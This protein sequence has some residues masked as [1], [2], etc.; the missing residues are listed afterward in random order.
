MKRLIILVPALSALASLGCTQETA[1]ATLRALDPVGDLA[2]VCLGRDDTGA[3]TQGHRRSDC[4]D[5]EFG[6]DS[7][8]Q[9]RL[10]LLVTQPSTGEVALLD[11][12][13]SQEDA[14]IDFEP[15]QPGYSFMP[16]GAEPGA[17]VSTPGSV[18]SF[19]GVREAG[20][21]GVFALPSSCLAPRAAGEPVRDIRS[22][23][24]C[25]LPAA[26]GPM[27]LLI[28]PALDDDG[29]PATPGL[30]RTSC[31]SEPVDPTQLIGQ[32]PGATRAV[33]PA[34]L[35]TETIQPGRRKLAVTLPSLAEVWVLDA[36]ELL[37]REPGSFDACN[38]EQRVALRAD[39]TSAVQRVPA[40]LTPA[41]PACAPV[42]FGHGPATDS[43]VPWPLDA[44]LDDE[45]RLF[46]SDSQ[47]PVIHVLDAS[48]PCNLSALPSLE[49]RSFTDPSAVVTT[50]RL[51]VSPLTPLGKR[52]VYAI[53]DSQTST[54][55]MLMAFDVSPGSN[56]RTPIVRER[57]ALNPAE[58]PDRIALGR[59]VA[60]V[61]FV[62]QDF[63]EFNGDV[64][65]EGI[66][67]D[68]DPT[69]RPDS[70]GADYRPSSD[71]TVGASPRKLR[72][73]FAFAALLSGQIAVVDVEDLD[74]ACRRPVATNP[75][76]GD[77][78]GGCHGDPTL[79]EG[80]YS[81][82]G[83]PTVTD[84]LSCNVVAPHRAR[85]R[86]FFTNTAG[87]APSV[88]L[89]AFPSLTLD[90]G[91]SVTTDQSDD[92]RD[93]PKL[94]PAR[95]LAGQAER[96]FVGPIQYDTDD[97]SSLL[98]TDPGTAQRSGLLL[99][100]EEPRSFVPG[101]DFLATYEGAVRQVSESL[102]TVD[103][104]RGLGRVNEGL[105]AQ[106]CSAGVQDMDLAAEVG[107]S[108]GVSSAAALAT[109]ARGHADYVQIV[110]D[111]LEEDHPYW[112]DPTTG[113]QCGQELFQGG[114]ATLSGHSLCEQFFGPIEIQSVNRDFR[115]VEAHQDFLVTEPRAYDPA[116]M[117]E[118][119][120]R[121]LSEFAS[122][123]FPDS[124]LYQIRAGSQWVVRGAATGFAHD[125][126]TDPT[127]L[128]CVADCNPMVSRQRGRAYEIS[129]SRDCPTDG[130][131]PPIGYAEPG[132]D[133]A[134]VVDDVENGIDP[135]EPG[136]ACVF[137]NLTTRFAVY[138]GQ[139][140]STRDMR[141][142]WQLTDGF[143]PL[144]LSLTSVDRTRSTPHSLSFLP[145]YGQLV[146]GDGSARGLTFVSSR[147]LGTI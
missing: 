147:N 15:T 63:P 116:T 33:C 135:G 69:L 96:L 47:A 17:I 95:R 35:A 100:Y 82:L 133:V 19:V 92:G 117:S 143:T 130:N 129:C 70:P 142:R 30:I 3:F 8:N 105:N 59:D 18:A 40:D 21:E 57:S 34:D 67:C 75:E 53:D 139:Q 124:T 83:L 97:P 122:C 140:A 109:F 6:S 108:L 36:Q 32:A 9:R 48:D 61:E 68:P 93:F 64:A 44:A 145:E 27:Q 22:W 65:V 103:P 90:T 102:F 113:G 28:D 73:T 78:I 14:V 51:A 26:P 118:T 86:S 144:V 71:L 89:V 85:S 115:I 5:F 91:R 1:T 41:S 146:V 23:P 125:V 7:P 114:S 88:G 4:P 110:G 66:A 20:R 29:D 24:A 11:M 119:R 12:G 52:F 138:R 25:R 31:G 107:R 131:R 136:A 120:R 72:G 76:P 128:R 50:S 134:C 13:T 112:R 54:S 87:A 101:E 99:S 49:P 81:F 94:L 43:F 60:D 80:V 132:E 55:G 10:H 106:F 127:T 38:V 84:E 56:E 45:Q 16:V 37:D 39:V 2:V 74:G 126:T 77:D 79:P 123:C 58:P 111:L 137:Q 98:D 46:L 141:F 121:Q 42:G 62:Y 104:V